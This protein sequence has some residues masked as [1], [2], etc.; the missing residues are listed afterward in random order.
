MSGK[1]PCTCTFGRRKLH[2]SLANGNKAD[3]MIDKGHIATKERKIGDPTASNTD[4]LAEKALVDL[5]AW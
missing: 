5:C 3:S 2:I 4:T 1:E